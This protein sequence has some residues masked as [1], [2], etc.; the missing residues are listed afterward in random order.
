M[1]LLSL[2]KF[3]KITALSFDSAGISP[4][5]ILISQVGEAISLIEYLL[6]QSGST[7]NTV[8]KGEEKVQ[9]NLK[10]VKVIF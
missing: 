3:L 9:E 4:S 7:A 2:L 5:H 8:P 1:F 6:E 10:I